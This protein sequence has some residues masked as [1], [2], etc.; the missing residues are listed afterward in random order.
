MT[1]FVRLAIGFALF[2]FAVILNLFGLMRIAPI[3][4]TLPLL[5]ISIYLLLSFLLQRHTFRGFK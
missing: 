4:I 5:F 2:I 3:L 1:Q